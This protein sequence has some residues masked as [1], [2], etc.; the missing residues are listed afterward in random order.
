[1]P[2]RPKPDAYPTRRPPAAR[3]HS[4][5]RRPRD[6]PAE[7]RSTA[8][9]RGASCSTRWS[10]IA[11]G[12]RRSAWSRSSRSCLFLVRCATARHPLVDLPGWA[13]SAATR[14]WSGALFLAI[15]LAGVILA[16]ATADVR[17]QVFSDRGAWYLLGGGD[18]RGRVRPA[19]APRGIAAGPA[20]CAAAYAGLGRNRGQLLRRAAALIAA[21]IDIPIFARTTVY[22][23]S[24]LMA[25]LV[26][27]KFLLAL[28][29]GAIV[30]RLPDRGPAA[31]GWSPR[32]G[33][34]CLGRRLPDDVALGLREPARLLLEHRAGDVRLRVRP[35]ARPR[36]RGRAR[37][38]RRRRTRPRVGDG[39]G[40]P[41]GGDAGRHL[42]ADR[43]R[44]APL[45]RRAG[46][47]SGTVT[48]TCGEPK[49]CTAYRD[50]QRAAGVAQEQTVFMGAVF[51]AL[52]AGM[53]RPDRSSAAPPPGRSTPGRALRRIG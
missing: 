53:H 51:C 47:R 3:H 50:L 2:D 31:P 36:Q 20:R 13:R 18:R 45:L 29:V 33:W 44:A 9:S 38:H 16:F 27:V 26:L 12:S 14:T 43:D 49:M 52:A 7:P 11:A 6:D 10:A 25:A 19:P 5:G 8:T 30:G 1:M 22:R 32:S 48:E 15:A 35:R 24:Q 40:L 17:V 28:P 37:Q 34:R 39:R 46:P 23:T 42:R 41:D 4:G 21:L